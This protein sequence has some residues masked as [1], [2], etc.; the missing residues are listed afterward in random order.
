[1]NHNRNFSRLGLSIV[2]LTLTVLCLP[3]L[4]SAAAI[5]YRAL[6]TARS[7]G[8]AT[9]GD[10]ADD[11]AYHTPLLLPTSAGALIVDFTLNGTSGTQVNLTPENL[12][13]GF[14][15]FGPVE[16]RDNTSANIAPGSFHYLYL[17]GVSGSAP[18]STP[19]AG[20]YFSTFS[21]LSKL[22]ESAV[23][24]IDVGALTI[25]PQWI[26][27]DGSLPTTFVFVQSNHVYAGGDP[28]AFLSRYP[29]PVTT[30]TLHLEILSLPC[31]RPR[32]RNR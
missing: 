4:A 28:A 15:Y 18:G 11:T 5:D 32:C 29:A 24:S 31:N 22:S 13:E 14:P 23:W 26:N 25:A 6:I 27:T 30:V 10:L 16:G 8:G 9:L 12:A 19:L 20:N 3:A 7:S 1:M 2:L 21:G 17:G